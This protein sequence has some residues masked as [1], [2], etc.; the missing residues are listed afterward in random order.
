M[1]ASQPRIC[2][3]IVMTV[4]AKSWSAEAAMFAIKVTA[5]GSLDCKTLMWS[6]SR[7][8]TE[9]CPIVFRGDR[10]LAASVPLPESL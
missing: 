10:L 6:V 9:A 5:R 3:S 4:V 1:T 7:R 2:S 8:I